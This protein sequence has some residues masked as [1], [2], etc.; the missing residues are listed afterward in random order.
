MTALA[1]VLGSL[2]IWLAVSATAAR[3]IGG[4]IRIAD[5]KTPPPGVLGE[6]APER[7]AH[8]RAAR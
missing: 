8:L 2:I 3:L 5:T 6:A 7:R 1:I 4:V